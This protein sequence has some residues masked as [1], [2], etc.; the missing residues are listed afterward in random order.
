[1]QRNAQRTFVSVVAVCATLIIAVSCDGMFNAEIVQESESIEASG[2]SVYPKQLTVDYGQSNSDLQARVVPSN[3][4]EL[5]VYWDSS[6]EAVAT[7][8]ATGVVT[9]V[10]LG[11]T[12]IT[13][14]TAGGD[15][16]D[17]VAVFV[18]G[19]ELG[20]IGPAGGY[21]FYIDE[22]NEHPG[23]TYLEA[24]PAETEWVAK[25]WG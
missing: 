23:W 6:D 17:T 12:E 9:A 13:A 11:T 18:V 25:P 4:T 22:A 10:S 5:S 24:A 3:A 2:I 8:D 7:V 14:T 20:D 21:I 1:M 19:Y 16:S 15:H